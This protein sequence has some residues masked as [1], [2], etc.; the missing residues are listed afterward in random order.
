VSRRQGILLGLAFLALDLVFLRWVLAHFANWGIWDWDYQQTLLEV[1]RRSLLDHGEIPL[2]NPFL[3]GGATLA[4]NTLS[5][6]F[7]P[8][9]VPILLFG[10]IAGIKVCIVLYL[11]IAQLGMWRLSR[12]LGTG[13]E[14]ATL[15]ALVFSLGG[16]FAQHVTHGHFEWIAIAWIPF[17]VLAIERAA[18]RIEARPLAGGA[19]AFAFL[20]LDGGPYQ[21]AIGSVLFAAY[22]LAR[23]IEARTARPLGALAALVTLGCALAA[24]KALPVLDTV[25]RYPRETQEANFYGAP[26]TPTALEM[27]HQMLVARAQAHDPEQWM[28]YLLNVGAYVGW[29]PLLLAL[30]AVA[31]RPRRHAALALLAFAFVWLALGAAAPL[32]LWGLLHALPGFSML[33]VPARF[34]VCVLVCLALLA[35]AG[36]D[37]LR[38][39]LTRRE[40]LARALAWGLT[41]FVAADLC[42]VNGAIFRVAF[43]VPPLAPSARGDLTHYEESPYLTAY[44]E[45][46]VYP[47]FDNW[48]G[49]AYPALLENRGV[50]DTYDTIPFQPRALAASNRDYRGEAWFRETGGR[51][52]S[53]R[54][55]PNRIRV[56]TDGHA[57]TLVFNVNF[58][59]G[60]TVAGDGVSAPRSAQGL[61]AVAVPGGVSA[62]ELRYRPRSFRRGAAVSG[63]TLLGLLVVWTRSRG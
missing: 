9:F 45:R 42:L 50:I 18:A 11:G 57:G 21:L 36:L 35:G 54:V 59:P 63:L 44:R 4:G 19:V 55:T 39:G 10:T 46:A 37:A 29:L 15:A 5:H 56:E 32:D 41:A 34:N 38:A 48:P 40:R 52:E 22:G 23:A 8:S 53:L 31:L 49:A 24:V 20:F 2:W 6:V 30:G 12:A 26:F 27:L 62:L 13:V 3:G 47:V 58:D 61:L 25:L 1:A 7:A 51:I 14:G 28:P 17:V 16:A 60:W 33:R 43:S